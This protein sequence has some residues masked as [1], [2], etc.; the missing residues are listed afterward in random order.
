MGLLTSPHQTLSRLAGSVPTNFSFREGPGWGPGRPP[1][2][3]LGSDRRSAARRSR[4]LLARSGPVVGRDPLTPRRADRPRVPGALARGGAAS[5][6]AALV[7][8][9]A[10]PGHRPK[11]MDWRGPRRVVVHA[12]RLNALLPIKLRWL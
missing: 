6:V 1:H 4:C 7:R 11:V 5:A 8:L 12:V 9:V 10:Q 2:G 3:R